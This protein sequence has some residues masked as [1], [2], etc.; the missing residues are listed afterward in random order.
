MPEADGKITFRL[1]DNEAQ[2]MFWALINRVRQLSDERRAIDNAPGG[3]EP[4]D[5]QRQQLIEAEIVQCGAL[6]ERLPTYRGGR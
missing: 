3:V 1:D 2:A 4:W 6:L 5:R